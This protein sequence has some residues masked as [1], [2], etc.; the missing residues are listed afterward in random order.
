MHTS[1]LRPDDPAW[2]AALSR[3]HRDVYHLPGYVEMAARRQEP[4]T[5]FAFVAEDD[6]HVFFVP[7][8]VRPIPASIVGEDGWA[9]A[10]SPRGYPGPIAGPGDAA[11]TDCFPERAIIALIETL[12]EE[13]IVSVY[14][15][16]HPLLSP[17]LD[18]L[19]Q[20]GRIIEHGDSVSI[21][22]SRS[23]D[24]MWAETRATHRRHINR[25]RRLGY[26]ARMDESWG[27]FDDFVAAYGASMD[28]LDAAPH[29]RLGADYFMDLRAA[30][31]EHLHLCVVELGDELAAA[32][33]IGE[34][35][36]LVEYHLAGTAPAHVD[37][38]PSKVLIDFVR[39]WAKERGDRVLHLAGSLR[40]DD[41]LIYFKL[42]FSPLLH[43]V[44]SMRL[45][46]MPDAYRHL[47]QRRDRL[48]GTEPA[49]DAGD[50][51]F[52][53]YRRPLPQ[54]DAVSTGG[55]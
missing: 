7:L 42:G 8:I 55:G 51:F 36:G 25:G 43:P 39:R 45:I 46:A 37:A 31:G 49:D 33:L 20:V 35:D 48:A 24:E 40:R 30:L 11:T 12:R 17:P 4:G 28:R 53:A 44:S 32:A 18:I 1:L 2:M 26:R 47:S 10:T 41:P 54:D 50:D 29:W 3:I 52:P 6:G 38:S 21:D 13:R 22:L 9:D 27:R 23:H 14:L 15:R 16:L 34:I 5:P 19:R